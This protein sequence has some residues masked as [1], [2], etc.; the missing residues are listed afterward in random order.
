MERSSTM[1]PNDR[2][3]WKQNLLRILTLFSL[4]LFAACQITPITWATPGASSTP[5]PTS[6]YVS[7]NSFAVNFSADCSLLTFN[8]GVD[9]LVPEDQNHVTD[10]FL[11]QTENGSI[12]RVRA[13]K[14]DLS[15]QEIPSLAASLSANGSNFLFLFGGRSNSPEPASDHYNFIYLRDLKTSQDERIDFTPLEKQ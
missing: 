8:S 1:R 4:L 9:G 5:S 7:E 10:P 13:E 14:S 11:Y 2:P 15:S 3:P 6:T 12:Q